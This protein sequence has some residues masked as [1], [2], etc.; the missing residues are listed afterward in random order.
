MTPGKIGQTRTKDGR[1]LIQTLKFTQEE[2]KNSPKDAK[3]FVKFDK[4]W[5]KGNTNLKENWEKTFKLARS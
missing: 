1:K 3:K 4:K 2:A 5:P